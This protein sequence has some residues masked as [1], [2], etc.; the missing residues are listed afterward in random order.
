MRDTPQSDYPLAAASTG[1]T[2]AGLFSSVVET[3]FIGRFLL[4]ARPAAAFC[5][6]DCLVPDTVIA[7]NNLT[8]ATPRRYG[9]GM[10]AED[11]EIVGCT[12]YSNYLYASRYSG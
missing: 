5:A 10:M 9:G 6:Y 4:G 8:P 3:N 12:L 1:S 7:A 11:S 2:E